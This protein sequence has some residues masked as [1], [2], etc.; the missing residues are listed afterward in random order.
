MEEYMFL[1][2]RMTEGISKQ[3]FFDSFRQDFD[4]TYGEVVLK[5][6]EQGLLKEEG[7]RIFLT[8]KGVDISN[9]VLAE[10]LLD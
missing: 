10:F 3:E 4:F 9:T 5:L 7:D 8:D 1:G 6:K 2:L